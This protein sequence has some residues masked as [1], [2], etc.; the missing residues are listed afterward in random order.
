MIHTTKSAARF[1]GIKT[2]QVLQH[3]KQ[4]RLPARK[5]GQCREWIISEAA[6]VRLQQIQS[7][8]DAATSWHYSTKHRG[9]SAVW[10]AIDA[11]AA[12]I[13]KAEAAEPTIHPAGSAGKI[14]VLMAR[15]RFSLPL[16]HPQ[17]N[18]ESGTAE[19]LE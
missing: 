17:D 19:P 18:P 11:E 6:L 2:N 8:K 16:Y 15:R 12:R 1:L 14:A 5:S 10:R 7:E 3:I 13:K 9:H 4:G